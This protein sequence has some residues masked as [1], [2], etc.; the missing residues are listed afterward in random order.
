MALFG[1]LIVKGLIAGSSVGQP[2]K[3]TVVEAHLVALARSHK[4]ILGRT[5]SMHLPYYADAIF[6]SFDFLAE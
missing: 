5:L 6:K 4:W 1:W 3:P 2:V